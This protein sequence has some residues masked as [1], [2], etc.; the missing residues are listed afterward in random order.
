MARAHGMSASREQPILIV[1]LTGGIGMGK[2]TVGKMLVEHGYPLLDADQV[3]CL[4]GGVV[5]LGTSRRWRAGC[6]TGWHGSAVPG[7]LGSVAL[8]IECNF[9]QVI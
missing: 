5:V 2:T 8:R 1:G 4:L 3:G 9:H 6:L 7:P